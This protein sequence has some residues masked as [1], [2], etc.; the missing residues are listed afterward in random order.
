MSIVKITIFFSKGY[1]IFNNKNNDLKTPDK[2]K[3]AFYIYNTNEWTINI[4]RWMILLLLR[5]TIQ[6]QNHERL[7]KY[8]KIYSLI[9]LL[10]T[11]PLLNQHLRV[12]YICQTQYLK[13]IKN[14]VDSPN[15][16]DCFVPTIPVKKLKSNEELQRNKIYSVKQRVLIKIK[17]I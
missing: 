10:I 17:S 4:I 16:F 5:C 15:F 7:F 12:S 2:I 1:N 8:F 6:N 3:Y 11:K 9:T 13:F 14:K